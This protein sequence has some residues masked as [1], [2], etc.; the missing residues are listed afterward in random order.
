LR[1]N[2]FSDRA[3]TGPEWAT[4]CASVEG[5]TAMKTTKKDQAFSPGVGSAPAFRADRELAVGWAAMSFVSRVDA[6]VHCVGLTL[7]QFRVLTYLAWQTSTPSRL[8]AALE[9]RPP[10]V[11]RLVDRLVSLG[12]VERSVDAN[13][14]RRVTQVV[15]PA[16]WDALELACRAIAASVDAV[17]TE[18]ERDDA[19]ALNRGLLGWHTAIAARF[20]EPDSGVEAGWPSASRTSARP[21]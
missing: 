12:F 17:E 19:D 6:G 16:G 2:N 11:T 9:T 18:M 7:P 8:A 10:S 15:T 5:G 13:D 1:F 14:R 4:L 20:W 21:A 3:R